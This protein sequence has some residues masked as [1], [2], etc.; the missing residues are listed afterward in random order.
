MFLNPWYGSQQGGG[1]A[2]QQQHGGI[3]GLNLQQQEQE[4]SHL[5]QTLLERLQSRLR[6]GWTPH[7][8]RDGRVYYCN[9]ASQTS[10][11]LPPLENWDA[12]GQ[13]LP[14]G[15]E[16]ATDKEGKPYFINHLN[17]TTTYEDPRK[18]YQDEPPQPRQIDLI[19]DPEMGFGFV[20]GSEKPVIVRFV[21]EGGPSVEKLLPGDQILM[22]NG[23]DV[24]K[25]PRDHVIQLVRSCK[26][27]VQLTVTQ[28][29]LDNSERKSALL[30][31]AKKQ[32]LKNN[33]SRVRF[34]ESVDIN[35]SPS[36]SPSNF[37]SSES[38][39]PFMPNVLK[40]F[41]EN[42]QTKSFKYDSSTTVGDVLDS[43]HQKLGIKCPEHFSL[44]V[45]HV[46]SLRRN[47]LTILDPKETLSRIAARPGAQ[48]LRCLYRVTFVPRDAYDLLRKDSMAFEYLY[49]Q[50][51][52]DVI[53]ERF[54]PEL[55]FD[56]ALR[57]A[58]LH[59]QQHALTNNMAAKVSVKTIEKD[60]GLERF[61]P[62]SYVDSMKRKELRKILSHFLKLN[63]NLTA[64]GQKQLTALQAKLH[65]LKI[66]SELP[67]YGAKCFSTN[68]KD[69]NMETVILIS[70]RFGISQIT[71]I[72]NSMPEALCEI[73]QVTS[74]RVSREDELSCRVE[75]SLKDPDKENLVVS[76]E[77]RDA[78]ELVLVLQ[79]YYRLL[80]ENPLAVTH[81]RDRNSV[82]QAPPYHSRHKVQATNWSYATTNE[83][84]DSRG[85]ERYVD[86]SV[87][88]PY[89]PPP[90]GYKVPNG[91]LPGLDMDETGVYVNS[92]R[93]NILDSN[94]NKTNSVYENANDSSS[95][96][97]PTPQSH[98][99]P[100]HHA[101]PAPASPA[102]HPPADTKKVHF[103]LATIHTHAHCGHA[104]DR[105]HVCEA[106]N[107]EVIKRV[108]ELQ[109]LVEDA[110]NY[111]SDA[112]GE[113]TDVESV[114]SDQYGRLKHSDS[115]LLLTQ[116]QK[117]LPNNEVVESEERSGSDTDSQSTPTQS[118]AHRPAKPPQ[119]PS[120]V[121]KPSGSS[122]GLHSPDNL[123]LT[124][125]NREDDIKALIKQLE[126]NSGLPYTFAEG[127]LYLDPDIIDLTMI[128]PPITPDEVRPQAY[129]GA[130][131]FPPQ[132]STPPTP[133]AD[134]ETLEKELKA[135]EQDLG[136][137][138]SLTNPSWL[139]HDANA[140][141]A[142]STT[143]GA[144]D[145]EDSMSLSSLNTSLVSNDS[146]FSRAGGVS[147]SGGGQ[148]LGR[149][150]NFTLAALR[151]LGIHLEEGEDI[152]SFIANLTIPPP[153]EG[154]VD[155]QTY[156][157]SRKIGNECDFSAFIIPPPPSSDNKDNRSSDI[158]RRLYEA[159]EGI[160]R[161]VGDEG[162]HS[163][164]EGGEKD[165]EIG[166]VRVSSET[167]AKRAIVGKVASLQ[168]RFEVPPKAA[169]HASPPNSSAS[170]DNRQLLLKLSKDKSSSP[171]DSSGYDSL[172]S[173]NSNVAY[174]L[175]AK[176]AQA[177]EENDKMFKSFDTL[178]RKQM[179]N[180]AASASSPQ[181]SGS[182]SSS[183]KLPSVMSRVRTFNTGS[184]WGT[185]SLQRPSTLQRQM[186]VPA[187]KAEAKD[188]DPPPPPPRTPVT[189]TGTLT[190][191]RKNAPSPPSKIQRSISMST[192]NLV[193]SASQ[194]DIMS[195]SGSST[196]HKSP[197]KSTKSSASSEDL[198]Q[199]KTSPG[200][201]SK[202]SVAS[203][204][205][206]LTSSS[207]I[208]TVKSASL[209]SL[210]TDEDPPELPPRN[211]TKAAMKPP[212]PRSSSQD[213]VKVALHNKGIRSPSPVRKTLRSPSP[214]NNERPPSVPSRL[215]K[216]QLSPSSSPTNS[217]PGTHRPSTSGK[218]AAPSPP[219]LSKAPAVSPTSPR[220]GSS[221]PLKSSPKT[222][223]KS[224]AAEEQ[225]PL[226]PAKTSQSPAR[227]APASPPATNG[228]R[229]PARSTGK[230]S[231]TSRL[232]RPDTTSVALKNSMNQETAPLQTSSPKMSPKAKMVNGKTPTNT[233][234]D[235]SL[236]SGS[237]DQ[238]SLEE[239][240]DVEM[241]PPASRDAFRRLS[242][243]VSSSLKSLTEMAAACTEAQ[244]SGGTA[245]QDETKFQEARDALTSE[246]R[247]FVTASKLFVKSATESE[248]TLLQCLSNCMTLLQ[249]MVDVT[250]Q[251]V[252]HTTT[253][254]Q[255]QNVVVKVR[256]VAT[257][258]QSTVR[259]ALSAAGRGMDHPS[260]N[261]LMTQA[262]NLAGVLTALMRTLRVF[263][264]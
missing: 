195:Q 153:P 98:A 181:D 120:S 216:P 224:P 213:N 9:H 223:R 253:P 110:E 8:T 246:S 118:P 25:A 103:N 130:K 152:D 147:G 229:S 138:R 31:A 73:E 141:Y 117:L 34:A 249:R 128:P 206:S 236:D 145:T 109:Q 233:D 201:P 127:T 254:L 261:T 125:Q 99:Y 156:A 192:G 239:A 44:V 119:R 24:K 22:I 66:I 215:R 204:N 220:G 135:L 1:V 12:G 112:D 38:T 218:L 148:V 51:C 39:T 243:L 80:T 48:H 184:P 74:A 240:E 89:K 69:T 209:K 185:S 159:K 100:S 211:G 232:P 202:Q 3:S 46:K 180:T 45:E 79:G 55:Q 217:I 33:P 113:I 183:E 186:T 107:E 4:P 17:K 75:L 94:M 28:P 59:I 160:S 175:D 250:R 214:D 193:K 197:T 106:R 41:L 29:P 63:S 187:G 23:E 108:A 146:V 32:R 260:M 177:L 244:R 143:T 173:N 207:S 237:F 131:V 30:S 2:S 255:T 263:S 19:R 167:M 52:N 68:M 10:S 144:S 62:S 114:R 6:P 123:P 43:L 157:E 228:V 164:T 196:I 115:L 238:D 47:K 88:P 5:L 84:D 139:D 27:R 247:Q 154:S 78:E 14:Y 60:C 111:L 70:P 242:L 150:P 26:D 258:Y 221:S 7:I 226:L 126:D 188:E 210:E 71:G 116:G 170:I 161:M 190:S 259:A 91:H 158:I 64:P 11:W 86:L 251:V 162:S 16:A 54:A 241:M 104:E 97:S 20:A 142:D 42:G 82:D 95:G 134:R 235:D 18:D 245:T 203:S 176:L 174:E 124:L 231:T 178:K 166:E 13:A 227:R 137:L 15:W 77:D 57:L 225:K 132:L 149:S 172:R 122:F 234:L 36:Y 252:H 90:E 21:T 85:T 87:P 56:V 257:T 194:G 140:S 102:R 58:A 129:D 101:H 200:S 40:V 248:D 155:L 171:S 222:S 83:E 53:Q 61:V 133:F 208:V 163:D 165:L 81:I 219:T 179:A 168:R 136:D 49:L 191:P 256:D 76:L 105:S 264:P 169:G 205:D 37:N 96:A 65:Y 35:G 121:L 230:A 212:L 50:C 151:Q 182:E 93:Q 67:S 262:T 72:R 92:R 198:S 189:R 199:A